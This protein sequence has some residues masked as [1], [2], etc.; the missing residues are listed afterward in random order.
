LAE[1]TTSATTA[2]GDAGDVAEARPPTPGGLLVLLSLLWLAATMW[3]AHASI[4]GNAAEAT[5]ALGTAASSLPVVVAAAVLLGAAAGFTAAGRFAAAASAVRRLA[6]GVAAGAACGLVASAVI[7]FGYGVNGPVA[8]LATTVG[9]AAVIGGTG[10]ALPG[11]ILHAGLGATL[12]AFVASVVINYFQ[13][14]LTELFG[15]GDTIASRA[16]AATLFAYTQSAVCGVVAA[17]VAFALL[18]RGGAE[19]AWPAYLVAGAGPGVML[20]LA[21]VLTRIGGASLIGL[22]RELSP[23]DRAVME[24][25]DSARLRNALVV[26]FVGG[27]VAMIAFGRTLRRPEEPAAGDD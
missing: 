2:D 13:S 15:A 26:G 8:V 21:D 14:P 23:G 20:L 18:R 16:E 1:D 25:G 7:L 27:I 24:Y 6:V 12:A 3:G 4:A 5:V 22:V 10:A 11:T 17:A 19:L 9:A